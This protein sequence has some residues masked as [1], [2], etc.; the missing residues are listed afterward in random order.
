VNGAMRCHMSYLPAG[1]CQHGCC[2]RALLDMARV[3][4]AEAAVMLALHC[5]HQFAQQMHATLLAFAA[6]RL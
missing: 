2:L 5:Q 4:S 6:D 3:L 1:R